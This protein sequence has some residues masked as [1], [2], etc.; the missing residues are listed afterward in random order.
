MKF[1][2]IKY[3]PA[4]GVHFEYVNSGRATDQHK[5]VFKSEDQP[6]NSFVDAL[7]SLR[8]YVCHA[9]QFPTSY[10]EGMAVTE[11]KL[12]WKNGVCTVEVCFVKALIAEEG[13]K[14]RLWKAA[15]P[16]QRLSADDMEELPYPLRILIQEAQRY[17]AGERGDQQQSLFPAPDTDPET[18]EVRREKNQYCEFAPDGRLIVAEDITL[19]E[20]LEE[21]GIPKASREIVQTDGKVSGTVNVPADEFLEM[22]E[23]PAEASSTG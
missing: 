20:I 2:K 10:M 16:K 19:D 21:C 12:D 11:I 22:A 4:K 14:T 3:D 9:L 7:A 23:E 13:G 15:T 17:I 8:E 1:T 6:L 5:T 18:G